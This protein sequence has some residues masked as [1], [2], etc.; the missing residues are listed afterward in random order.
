MRDAGEHKAS[1]GQAE[2]EGGRNR[3]S[4]PESEPGDEYALVRINQLEVAFVDVYRTDSSL[5]R[6]DFLREYCRN[7][8]R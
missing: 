4:N 8:C 5:C 1:A 7:T 6:I 3:I 2:R